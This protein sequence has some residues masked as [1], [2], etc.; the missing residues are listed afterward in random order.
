MGSMRRVAGE[1]HLIVTCGPCELLVRP[2]K[3]LLATAIRADQ[4]YFTSYAPRP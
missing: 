1:A 3:P 2:R 4:H